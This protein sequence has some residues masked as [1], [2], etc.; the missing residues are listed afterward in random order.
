MNKLLLTITC[1]MIAIGQASAKVSL[2]KLFSD[3]MVLQRG[4]QCRIWGKA[5]PNATVKITTSWNRRPVAVKSGSDGKFLATISTPLDKGPYEITL[6]DG[7]PTT[8]HNVLM[9]EVWV[10]SGQ[11]NM[12][13]PLKGF[14]GQP[15]EGATEAYLSA[16]D[17]ELRFIT[18][19]RN[20]SL[21]PADDITGQW[22]SASAATLRN[23]SATAYFFAR[24]LRQSLQVPVGIIV[25]AWGGSACEAWMAPEWLKD[26]PE[27]RK[28]D[29]ADMLKTQQRCP[30][31]LYYGMLR[32][33]AGYTMRG[34]LWYQGEDNVNRW[35]N[36][37]RL[38]TRM[39]HGW[40]ELWQQGKFPFYYA[41][42]APYDYS[43]ID[44]NMN[45]ANLRE[46]QRLAENP[47][48][49]MWMS[50]NLD[51][52]LE[53]GIHPRKKRT[54]G[55][56]LAL[57]ALRNTYDMKSLPDYARLESVT[58]SGDTACVAFAGSKEWIYFQ[59]GK[60]EGNYEVRAK[61]GSWHK[62]KAWI[63]RNRLYVKSDEVAQPDA[64]RYDYQDYVCADLMHDGLPVSSFSTVGS[65]NEQV[66]KSK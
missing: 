21:Q 28:P 58:F 44:W 2:P 5:T 31:A 4:A 61:D 9:G 26:F 11:S 59:N 63:N 29:E 36:Y 1:A 54:A 18:A 47:L 25:I 3:G 49:S 6:S 17:D 55:M 22:Q 53:Y 39:V 10:C 30:S 42:I 40:R 33:V 43:L 46:Q 32:P 56:R 66:K 15:V 64:V 50:V 38:L 13:M 37:S 16:P 62:A 24:T 12:E 27:V 7:T 51:A 23:F 20:A 52:G 45:S 19:K 35:Q 14:K 60:Q 8:L 34:V 41:Q 65:G 57:Q 48:D